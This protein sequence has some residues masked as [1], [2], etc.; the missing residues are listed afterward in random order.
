MAEEV[1]ASGQCLC[2]AVRIAVAGIPVR[3]A[4]CHCLDCR[5]ATGTGHAS[6]AIFKA[7]NVTINGA[8]ESFT[9]TADSGNVLT[10]HFCPACGS[11][12]HITNSA[13]PG[14]MILPV[15]L[16]NDSDW[17]KPQAILYAKRQPAWDMTSAEVPR[18]EGMPPPPTPQSNKR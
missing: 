14:M 5:R 4:Q 17:F 7:E 11:R 8:T 1:N 16:F 3:M 13:R 10:R 6:N 2:G 9:V 15:G 12:T 18:F